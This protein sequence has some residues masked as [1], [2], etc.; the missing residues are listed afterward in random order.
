MLDRVRVLPRKPPP[1]CSATRRFLPLGL[2][3]QA[4][5]A[6][7]PVATAREGRRAVRVGCTIGVGVA[8]CKTVVLAARVRPGHAVVPVHRMHR[9]V[10]RLAAPRIVEGV[11]FPSG[12]GVHLVPLG[13]RH[14]RRVHVERADADRMHGQLVIVPLRIE[15]VAHRETPR[16][17]QH[18]VPGGLLQSGG[19]QL[20]FDRYL[21]RLKHRQ[22]LVDLLQC[23]HGRIWYAW[24]GQVPGPC[25][26][27]RQ[28]DCRRYA[29]RDCPCRCLHPAISFQ[30][31][32]S[33][34]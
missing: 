12:P 31:L 27:C 28:H 25:A 20:A 22:P 13:L 32:T 19:S 8:R 21:I 17:D 33:F 6:R 15:R 26:D 3:R 24:R 1:A 29:S 11:A 7:R 2:R 10:R 16:R 5:S 9:V 34:L 30:L 23:V 4:V 14:L 18:H